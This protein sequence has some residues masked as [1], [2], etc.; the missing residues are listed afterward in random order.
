ME[1]LLFWIAFVVLIGIWASKWN[2][3]GFG[4]AV[5]SFFISPL[6][7]ALF[8]LAAGINGKRCLACVKMMPKEALVC[9]NCGRSEAEAHALRTQTALSGTS[10]AA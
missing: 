6:L 2:R 1:F 10:A 4:W 3:N 8:L 9:G 7:G 5:L